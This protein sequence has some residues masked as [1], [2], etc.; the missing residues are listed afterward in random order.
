M[1]GLK[2]IILECIVMLSIQKYSDESKI[3]QWYFYIVISDNQPS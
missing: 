3:V 2:H 1:N